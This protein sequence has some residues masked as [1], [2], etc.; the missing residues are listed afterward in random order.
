MRRGMR[1]V[2]PKGLG[3]G[4]NGFRELIQIRHGITQSRLRVSGIR[5]DR[6]RPAQMFQGLG[7]LTVAQI[8]DAQH[9]FLLGH[10][11]MITQLANDVGEQGGGVPP[12]GGLVKTEGAKREQKNGR[13]SAAHHP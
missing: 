12:I 11:R 5:L 4:G 3:I 1:G 2:K 13:H 6:E 9:Q 8:L 7:V 10:Q